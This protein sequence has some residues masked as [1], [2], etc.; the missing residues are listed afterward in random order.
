MASFCIRMWRRRRG[1][2]G[3]GCDAMSETQDQ[4][5][6]I[7]RLLELADEIVG[8]AL[9][10]G[11]DVAEA[12]AR[13]GSQLQVKVRLGEPELVEEA[14]HRGIGLRVI[15]NQRV[16]LTSTSDLTPKGIDLFLADALELLE[17]VTNAEH[18][19]LNRLD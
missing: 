6:R 2:A 15:K 8:R 12:V 3:V 14:G 16:A 7:D 10:G 1:L 19:L 5:D 11:A 17:V 18:S 4:Q 9:D 13:E